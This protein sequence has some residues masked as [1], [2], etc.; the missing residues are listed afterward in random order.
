MQR[1]TR[2]KRE[3]VLLETDPPQGISCWPHNDRLDLLCAR[4][5]N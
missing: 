5:F 3:L 1:E 4:K 2:V